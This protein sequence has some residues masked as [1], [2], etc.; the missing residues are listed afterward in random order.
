VESRKKDDMK[1]ERRLSEKR[2]EIRERKKGNV[3]VGYMRNQY[4]QSIVC[5]C[6]K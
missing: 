1:V 6:I 5:V 2:K 3:R 4:D